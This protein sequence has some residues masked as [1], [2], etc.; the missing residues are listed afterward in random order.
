MPP[1]GQKEFLED[2]Y[3]YP[4]F[5]K[6]HKIDIFIKKWDSIDRYDYMNKIWE[7]NVKKT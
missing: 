6:S 4:E 2:F 3:S 5:Y 7:E 1:F